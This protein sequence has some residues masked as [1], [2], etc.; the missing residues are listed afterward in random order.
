VK[1]QNSSAPA[2]EVSVPKTPNACPSQL[3]GDV[4]DLAQLSMGIVFGSAAG[5]HRAHERLTAARADFFRGDS[6][7]N[8]QDQVVLGR[9][10]VAVVQA[11]EVGER[12]NRLGPGADLIAGD[13]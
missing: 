2:T 13:R 1:Q 11:A 10:A 9:S 7:K 12:S 3:D 6:C 8:R 5:S 4:D